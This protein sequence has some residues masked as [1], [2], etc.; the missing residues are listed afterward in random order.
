MTIGVLI[1]PR[2]PHFFPFPVQER[3]T[4]L[5]LATELAPPSPCGRG[6]AL[7]A[8]RAMLGGGWHEPPLPPAPPA[9]RAPSSP[10][11]KGR[12]RLGS[13]RSLR[14]CG[15]RRQAISPSG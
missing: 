6:Q 10:S 15:S 11:P 8:Q 7:R 14:A 4:Q 3:A 5:F 9:S 12:G 2:S 1:L 13:R